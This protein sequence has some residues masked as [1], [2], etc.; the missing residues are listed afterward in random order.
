MEESEID[1]VIFYV[2]LSGLFIFGFFVGLPLL[3]NVVVE[4]EVS[5]VDYVTF[6]GQPPCNFGW[7]IVDN[8]VVPS[9]YS[10]VERLELV[11]KAKFK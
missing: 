6:G 2:G 1:K 4:K 8:Q 9:K 7:R 11:K 10:A 5:D 3:E